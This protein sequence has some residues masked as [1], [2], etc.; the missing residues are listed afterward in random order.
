LANN[1]QR[2]RRRDKSRDQMRSKKSE[3]SRRRG[4]EKKRKEKKR[5]G[6]MEPGRYL[7]AWRITQTGTLSVGWPL[8]A[9]NTK[10][11]FS[12]GNCISNL[13]SF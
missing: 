8:A 11:F 6:R 1:R 13:S 3:R 2:R 7:P 4:G 12:S 5:K 9:L 10:S